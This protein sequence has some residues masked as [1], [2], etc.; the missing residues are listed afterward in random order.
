MFRK[1]FFCVTVTAVFSV[2]ADAQ[3]LTDK[4]SDLYSLV[5][6]PIDLTDATRAMT[7]YDPNEDGFV[8]KDE[9]KRIRW[10]DEIE[11]Y[12]LNRDGK[13]THMEV[14]V[15]FANIR[16]EAG[17][18]QQ[19]VD[20]A[21]V[22]MRRHDKNKN[23]QLDPDEIAGGWPS[24]P[25]EFDKNRDGVITLGEVANRFSFMAGLRREMG[26]E[27]VDQV[28]AIRTVRKFDKN[29][30]QNLDAEE[31]A[32]AFLPLAAKDFDEDDNG[33]LSIMEI[34]TMLA[35]HRRESGMSQTDLMQVRSIFERF[36]V[37]SDGRI[38]ESEFAAASKRYG[39]NS[40]TNPLTQLDKNGDGQ[41]TQ[42]EV[43]QTMIDQRKSL[44]FND[45]QLAEAKKLLTRHD[46]NRSTF[47]EE[48]EF[49]ESPVSGQLEKSII[50]LA[51]IDNDRRVSLVELARYLAKQPSKD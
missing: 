48:D 36:D 49:Y 30:D 1:I 15:R 16:S 17:V 26:I 21:N 7:I 45:A 13:L 34:A 41:L 3:T 5:I 46:K 35:K 23:G 28:T 25:D 18:E 8:D 32:G 42:M 12:D 2:T 40:S 33:K 11:R 20:N 43:Q 37:N 51:D 24:D 50:E 9:Q 14:T 47:I 27:Q 6:A 10:Q 22:F 38:D 31:Q 19:H 4:K 29:K 44:G 39:P